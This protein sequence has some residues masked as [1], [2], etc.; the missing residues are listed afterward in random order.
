MSQVGPRPAPASVQLRA[1]PFP[2]SGLLPLNYRQRLNNEQL[3]ERD[4]SDEKYRRRKAAAEGGPVYASPTCTK[5]LTISLFFDGTNKHEES[6]SEASPR[7]TS[8]I[9]RLY[10]V[11][12][13]HG[14][15]RKDTD[16]TPKARAVFFPVFPCRPACAVSHHRK[17][18]VDHV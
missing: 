18:G 6:D 15:T 1:G 12:I 4:L 11:A 17:K 16:N 13:S 2:D 5:S 3:K 14:N 9:A 8:P 10:H 7:G